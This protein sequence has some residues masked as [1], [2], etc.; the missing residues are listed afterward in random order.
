MKSKITVSKLP[1]LKTALILISRSQLLLDCAGF[2][3]VGLQHS[4]EAPRCKKQKCLNVIAHSLD[5]WWLH[6][7]P[8]Q[9]V[10]LLGPEG[11]GRFAGVVLR[12]R[13]AASHYRSACSAATLPDDF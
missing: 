11:G 12:G 3:A 5:Y 7:V 6:R 1:R 10:E 2:L 13:S 8:G 4:E 9:L